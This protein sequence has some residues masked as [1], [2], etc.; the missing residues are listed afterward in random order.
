[1]SQWRQVGDWD[2]IS[3]LALVAEVSGVDAAPTGPD[4]GASDWWEK[5]RH[6]IEGLS[7]CSVE[8]LGTW[9]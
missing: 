4:L 1:M 8:A 9:R 6:G 3:L 7:H 2:V 5:H